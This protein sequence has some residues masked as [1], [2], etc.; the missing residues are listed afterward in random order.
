LREG[1]I[2]SEVYYPIALHLQRC[3][4]FLGHRRG[5]FPEAERAADEV[6]ALP[7]YPELSDAQQDRVV[8]SI[9]EFYR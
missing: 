1:G 3:F 7:L 2:G 8:A 4:E 6:L 5:D 9:V